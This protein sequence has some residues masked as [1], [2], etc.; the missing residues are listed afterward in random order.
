MISWIKDITVKVMTILPFGSLPF[1]KI[2][3]LKNITLNFFLMI[4]NEENKFQ[5]LINERNIEQ[6]WIKLIGFT[7]KTQ[8]GSVQQT[9]IDCMFQ[10]LVT[11]KWVK[12]CSCFQLIPVKGLGEL[13]WTNNTCRNRRRSMA[14]IMHGLWGQT[15]LQSNPGSCFNFVAL[16]KQLY[17]F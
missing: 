11:Q 12:L 6:Y 4:Q 9:F 15:G 3:N 5:E 14:V 16:S 10:M 13:I 2:M 8:L 1:W 7:F 17:S